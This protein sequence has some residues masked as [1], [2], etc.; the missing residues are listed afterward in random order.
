MAVPRTALILHSSAGLYGAD[1]ALLA[2]AAGLDPSRWRALVALP[3]RGELA[4]LLEDAGVECV[5]RPLAVLRRGELTPGGLARTARH[6][7]ADRSEL[8]ALARDRD[9]A[10]VHSNTSVLV[11][12]QSVAR[13]AGAAH[14]LHLREIY[15]PPG[16]GAV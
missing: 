7:R 13:A 8:G 16:A 5:T 15:A 6:A 11:A 14:L 2:M 4:P 1:R 10:V 12:G 9:V 3:E